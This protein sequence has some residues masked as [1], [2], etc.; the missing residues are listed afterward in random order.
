MNKENLGSEDNYP[1]IFLSYENFDSG[2]TKK[3]GKKKKKDI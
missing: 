2:V 1:N 3:K